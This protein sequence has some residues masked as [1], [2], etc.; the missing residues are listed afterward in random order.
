MVDVGEARPAR[1]DHENVETTRIRNANPWILRAKRLRVGDEG[2]S[3]GGGSCH[4]LDEV[5]TEKGVQE[6]Q[7]SVSGF[8][9]SG[10][11]DQ[12]KANT[13]LAPIVFALVRPPA[14]CKDPELASE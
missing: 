13:S 3:E 10:R 14:Y 2:F 7:H 11:T 4:G 12:K 1:H 6:L 9:Y 5:G 8:W